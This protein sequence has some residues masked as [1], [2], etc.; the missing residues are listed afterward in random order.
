MEDNFLEKRDVEQYL[1][2]EETTDKLIQRII[3]KF[4]QEEIYDNVLL[5]GLPSLATKL[6][7]M[8]VRVRLIDIDERF[9]YLPDFIN[10]D[11]NKPDSSKH[12]ILTAKN[13]IKLIMI[14]PPF[15]ALPLFRV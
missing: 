12:E 6:N 4:P 7:K 8:G 1:F 14:D 2:T 9:N 10:M 13:K 5:I 3:Q 15:F 11:L